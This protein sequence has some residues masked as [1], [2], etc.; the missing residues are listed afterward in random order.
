MASFGVLYRRRTIGLARLQG[1]H[2]PAIVVLPWWIAGEIF[3][4]VCAGGVRVDQLAHAGGFLT[5]ALLIAALRRP[6][7]SG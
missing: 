6:R 5:G 4:Y 7:R 3:V 1:F 2:A